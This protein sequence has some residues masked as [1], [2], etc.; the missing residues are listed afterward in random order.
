MSL[1]NQEKFLCDEILDLIQDSNQKPI[2][3]YQNRAENYKSNYHLDS[4]ECFKLSNEINNR[5]ANIA[6]KSMK[7]VISVKSKQPC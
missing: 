2:S 4:Q 5:I 7:V 3:Y 6:N 1:N